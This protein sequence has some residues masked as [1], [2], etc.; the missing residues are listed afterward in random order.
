[1][2]LTESIELLSTREGAEE[3]LNCVWRLVGNL[4]ACDGE[5]EVVVVEW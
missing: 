5:G 1:M 2:L 4:N 3:R